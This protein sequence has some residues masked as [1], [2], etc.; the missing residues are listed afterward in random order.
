[1]LLLLLR[2]PRVS[3][4][5]GSLFFFFFPFPFFVGVPPYFFV[6]CVILSAVGVCALLLFLSFSL[7]LLADL[8]QT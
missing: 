3:L 6:G 4:F 1:L 2:P 8:N 5:C 7:S